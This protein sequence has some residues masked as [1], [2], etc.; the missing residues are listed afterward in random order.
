MPKIIAATDL[1]NL[2]QPGLTVFVQGAVGEPLALGQALAEA[3][4]ASRGVHYVSCLVPGINRT[5]FAA[6]HDEARLTAFFVQAELRE[7]FALGKIRFLPLHYSGICSYMQRHE[8]MD[9]VLMQVAPPDADGMC[10]LGLSLD[11]IPLILNQA[12]IVV[13][14]VNAAMPSPPGS[15]KIPY[16]RLDYVVETNRALPEM[17]TGDLPEVISTIGRN[18]AAL[19][20]DGDCIQIGIGK[21][22]AAILGSLKDRRHLGLHGG[23]A[24]DEVADLVDAGALDG[25]KK[26][27]DTNYMIC[28]AAM[29][30]RRVFDWAADRDDIIFK[31][32]DYTHNVPIIA[33]VDNFVSIN[34]TLEVDLTGQANSETVGGRQ[35]SGTGGLVDFVRGAR[36][37]NNSRSVLALSATAARGKI[38]RIVPTLS[39]GAVVSCPRADI[40]YVVTEF[41]AARLKDKSVDERAEA[42]I[43][44]A[45]PSFQD[46]LQRQWRQQRLRMG[47]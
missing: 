10:S 23:M 40:D 13:A 30:T 42:L 28:G 5:D 44:I 26:S 6:F 43:A 27:I 14:E 29:G 36:M 8:P 3:G 32:A 45:D 7:S 9:I 4:E 18:V 46:D 24:T 35:I 37:G 33:Q 38:S 19:I 17:P 15:P 31:G 16:D 21:V 25:S 2:L 12:K 1:A 41:G 22:P 39:D 34:S 47:G 20:N 11:F